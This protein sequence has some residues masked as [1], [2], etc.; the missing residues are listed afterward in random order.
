MRSSGYRLAAPPESFYVHS[1]TGPLRPGETD[2]ARRWGEALGATV[3]HFGR[4]GERA[5]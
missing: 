4:I 5:P 1:A 3:A 2:R